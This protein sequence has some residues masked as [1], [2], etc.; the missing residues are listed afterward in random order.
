MKHPSKKKTQFISAVEARTH[1]GQL[2]DDVQ[3][4][5]HHLII[6]RQGKPIAVILSVEE[7]EDYLDMFYDD[8]PAIEEALIKSQSDYERG[9]VGSLDDLYE[10]MKPLKDTTVDAEP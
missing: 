8:P 1:W 3:K 4:G 2:L 7:F 10:A 9:D 6:E 5:E